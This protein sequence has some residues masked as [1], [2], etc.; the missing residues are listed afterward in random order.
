MAD[1]YTD[2]IGETIATGCLNY[3]G[4]VVA[5]YM[6]K[7][8]ELKALVSLGPNT[9]NPGWIRKFTVNGCRLIADSEGCVKIPSAKPGPA[10]RCDAAPEGCWTV[11]FE[12]HRY[13]PTEVYDVCDS[14]TEAKQVVQD[15]QLS[16]RFSSVWSKYEDRRQAMPKTFIVGLQ[17]S[18]IYTE[19]QMTDKWLAAYILA[20]GEPVAVWQQ[21]MISD[22]ISHH[23]IDVHCEEIDDFQSLVEFH[24]SAVL[25]HGLAAEIEKQ[26]DTH[27]VV[28]PIHEE[29]KDNA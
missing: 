22:D 26:D 20:I 21:L 17:Y 23:A 24:G 28:R 15:L 8:N 3:G 7:D 19:V 6:D 9:Q 27:V 10:P 12:K 29:A 11:L 25:C 16:G 2:L 1:F 4:R 13:A 18:N 5:V 14:E